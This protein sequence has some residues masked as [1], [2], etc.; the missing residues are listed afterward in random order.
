MS[1]DVVRDATIDVLLR[2]TER[3]AFLSDSIDKTLRRKDLSDR[4]ARFLTQLAY[5]TVR[6]QRLSDHVLQRFLKQPLDA[7][8]RPIH[9]ILRMGVFQAM[10]CRQVTFPAMVHTSVDLAKKRG[11]PGTAK[12]VNAVLKRVP[13]RIEDVPLPSEEKLVRYLGVRYSLPDW[14]VQDWLDTFGDDV[15]RAMCSAS[16]EQAPVTIRANTLKGSVDQLCARL[17]QVDV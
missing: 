12:L 14:L 9:A 7:L 15:T 1:I 16:A 11:H 8:P 2:V 4:G 6:H 3:G 13:Q 5:G 10:F 17:A